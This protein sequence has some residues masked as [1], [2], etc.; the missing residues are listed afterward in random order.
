MGVELWAG[1]GIFAAGALVYALI[2]LNKDGKDTLYKQCAFLVAA[3]SLTSYL[4][5]TFAPAMTTPSSRSLFFGSPAASALVS[6]SSIVY[7]TNATAFIRYFDFIVSAPTLLLAMSMLISDC[8]WSFTATVM[9]LG[10]LTT[11]CEMAG[12]LSV[13]STQV[14]WG[15][16]VVFFLFSFY[17]LFSKN[18]KI[19]RVAF[20]FEWQSHMVMIAIYGLCGIFYRLLWILGPEGNK[21]VP[22]SPYAITMLCIDIIFK[23][24]VG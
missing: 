18:Q 14:F 3:I 11:A 7:S 23:D 20:R 5:S 10:A 24:S 4:D 9:T 1:A 17:M 15:Y 21:I 16:S 6:R 22:S 13:A 12:S 2:F 19:D 8:N